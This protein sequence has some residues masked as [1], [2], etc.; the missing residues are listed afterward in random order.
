MSREPYAKPE[1]RVVDIGND[2]DE[3]SRLL[4]TAA[5][6]VL[7]LRAKAEAALETVDR[8]ETALVDQSA[9]IDK[10]KHIHAKVTAALELR[11]KESR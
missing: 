7:D 4:D 10:A 2:L 6:T 9:E 8:L 11:D 1:A 5:K 3:A